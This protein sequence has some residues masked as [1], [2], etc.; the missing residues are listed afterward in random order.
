[1]SSTTC[2]EV[3]Y[4]LEDYQHIVD[5]SKCKKC[6]HKEQDEFDDPCYEC[7]QN[8]TN[9]ATRDPLYFEKDPTKKTRRKKKGND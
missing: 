3:N 5:F 7:L 2:G 8:A 1:M 6:I 9:Y 4:I